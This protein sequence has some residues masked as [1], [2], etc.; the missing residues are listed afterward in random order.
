MGLDL[1]AIS[2]LGVFVLLGM[3]RGL[4]PSGLGLV[5][6]VLGYVNAVFAAKHLAPIVAERLELTALVATPLVG[7][8]G[9]L[10]TAIVF[11]ILTIPLR[12]AD[13]ER[14]HAVGRDLLDRLGGG[15][16]GG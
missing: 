16:L 6:L 1:I 8:L 9:F 14:A 2:A 5:S 12:R 13:R 3:W 10:A 11:S 7:T 15:L 4:I